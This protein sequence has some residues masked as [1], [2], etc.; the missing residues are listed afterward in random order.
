LGN[1][2]GSTFAGI[3]SNVTQVSVNTLAQI[4]RAVDGTAPAAMYPIGTRVVDASYQ[5]QVPGSNYSNITLATD[6]IYQTTDAVSFGVRLTGNITANIGD[7]LTQ[8]QSVDTWTSNTTITVGQLT[9]Y[10]G[11]T[12]TVTGNVNSPTFSAISANVAFAFS[13]NTVTTLQMRLLQT[14]ANVRVVP[15]IITSGSVSGLPDLFDSGVNTGDPGTYDNLN[16]DNTA[17][18]VSVNGTS[19]NVYIISAYTLGS[20]SGS[21]NVTMPAGTDL[22]YGNVWYSPGV[23]TPSNDLGLINSTTEQANFLKAS[24]GYTP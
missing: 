1:V 11:N 3:T 17:G 22:H 15:V 13:G 19:A 5:Q 9:Y 2:F 21:G 6:K 4:R 20:V 12:Y 14:V 7:I 18:K 16:F 23:G 8:T 24:K 10:S